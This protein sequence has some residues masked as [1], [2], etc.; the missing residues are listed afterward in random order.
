[1]AL[2]IQKIAMLSVMIDDFVQVDDN[3]S[4]AA[5]EVV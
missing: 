5:S 3:T 4:S 1:M 2:C